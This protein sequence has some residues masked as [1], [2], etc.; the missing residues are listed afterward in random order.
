[1]AANKALKELEQ[2]YK[3]AVED[4][5]GKTHQDRAARIYPSNKDAN[6]ALGIDTARAA[7]TPP[8]QPIVITPRAIDAANSAAPQIG[9]NA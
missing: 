3:K 1:M 2:R 6:R 9:Q 8:G 4:L 7:P 5:A